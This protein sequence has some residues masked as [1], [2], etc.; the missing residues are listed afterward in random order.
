MIQQF[1]HYPPFVAFILMTLPGC[2]QYIPIISLFL[3][4]LH[5]EASKL[6]EEKERKAVSTHTQEACLWF[7]AGILLC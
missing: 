7:T 5:E 6:E 2:L 1:I 3:D 4:K